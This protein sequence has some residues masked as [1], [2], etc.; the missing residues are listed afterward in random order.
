MTRSHSPEFCQ[1]SLCHSAYPELFAL[2]GGNVPNLQ[3]RTA[4]GSS[5]PGQYREAGLPNIT[6]QFDFNGV[7]GLF[8]PDNT[9]GAFYVPYT[10]QWG[11]YGVREYVGTGPA[12][13]NASR[14]S[15]VYGRSATVQ[16]AAYTVRFLIRAQP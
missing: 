12:A 1:I 14:C 8:R 11:P 10:T 16:P 3:E 7:H 5:S 6:G 15:P 2:T 13:M 4:W 9:S